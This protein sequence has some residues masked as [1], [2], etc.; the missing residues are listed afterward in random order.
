MADTVDLAVDSALLREARK[1]GVDVEREVELG[2]RQSI[3]KRKRQLAWQEEN[4]QAIDAWN[5][6][7]E[8]NGLWYERLRD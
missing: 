5:K 4:R 7:I 1:L 3:D 8:K 6:E 2:L